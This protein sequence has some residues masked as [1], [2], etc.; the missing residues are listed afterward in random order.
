MVSIPSVTPPKP[1]NPSRNTQYVPAFWLIS[2]L[3]YLSFAN[4]TQSNITFINIAADAGLDFEHTDGKS[5]MRLF[6][7]Y[8]GAGGGFF[9]YNDDGHLD[10][11]L[12]NGVPQTDQSKEAQLPIPA[13][14]LY[15]NN[16]DGTFSNVTSSAGVGDPDY[17]VGC[18]VGDFDNDGDLDLY[19]TNFGPNVFYRNNGDG[20]FVEVSVN[21]GVANTQWGTSCAFADVDND[22][23]LDLYIANYADYVV[24]KDKRC[25][26]RGIWQY[27]GPGAYPPDSD[28][29]Y[30]N[31]GDG[32][33]T[34]FSKKSEVLNVPAYHGL[35]VAFADYDN[36]GDQDLYVANDQDANFLFQ[37]RGDGTFEEVALLSGVSYSDMGREEAGMGT[38]FGDYDN[39][40]L[41]DLTVSNFQNETNTLY[42]NESGDFFADVTIT[43]GIGE[44]TYSYLGW[45]IS[46]F[47]YDNDGNKDIFVA[48]GH[49]LD[50]VVEVDRSTTY[51]QQNL[52]FRN[53]GDGTF[54]NVTNQ[55]GSGLALR[56]VS[57]GAAFGDYDNDGDIDILIS[58]WNQ[59]ADLLRNE[60]GNLN[61]WVQ[62]RVVGVKSNRSGIGARIKV[63]AGDLSQFAEVQSGGSYLSFSD[64]RVHFG[65]GKSDKVDLVEIRW[66]SGQIDRA[67]NLS[68]NRQFVATEGHGLTHY[69]E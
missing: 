48:N 16:G 27:C 25:V 1:L 55:V 10:I 28:V 15:H 58:N 63:V 66:P 20:T 2:F 36:D 41:L 39:D 22:S 29:L 61:N 62:F 34:D 52:L 11:Y 51:P 44:V 42:H 38:A 9:D 50:N 49:V 57:R 47:D 43:T 13:N 59:S 68:V 24:E 17:G 32:T 4:T 37:N 54:A 53:L 33:F 8:L 65:L 56:K 35:G 18:A 31:N 40:G 21:A 14:A 3:L 67:E 26:I 23:F 19:V 30:H 7:E 12:V 5:D 69:Q 60:G 6:N 64:L 45:G 46:F